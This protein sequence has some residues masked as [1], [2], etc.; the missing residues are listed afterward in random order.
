MTIIY[1]TLDLVIIKGYIRELA[2]KAYDCRIIKVA[3]ATHRIDKR[4]AVVIAKEIEKR[5]LEDAT[6]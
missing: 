1:G 3:R 6:R 4:Y 5:I 2:Q